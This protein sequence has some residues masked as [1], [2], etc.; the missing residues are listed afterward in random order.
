[1]EITI[2]LA[3]FGD[4][5]KLLIAI[6]ALNEE[7]SI[8]AVVESALAARAT[9]VAETP[10]S[11]VDIT[12]VSDGST[13]RTA[14]IAGQYL[15]QINLII[16]DHNRG[17]GAAIKDAWERSDADLLGFMDAD[18]TCNPSFFG[19]LCR[20]LLSKNADIVLGSRLSAASRIPLIRR[21][22]NLFFSLLLTLF[23]SRLVRDAASGMRVVRRSCLPRLMPLPDGLHFTPAMS[24]RAVLSDD[25]K[26]FEVDMPY[27]ERE[28]R[29]KLGVFK[30]GLRFLRV[31]L[32]TT[33]LYRPSRPLV[34]FG[35]ICFAVASALMLNPVL[36]YFQHRSVL[37]WMIYRFVVSDLL[38]SSA[39]LFVC[40][41]Y[42]SRKVVRITLIDKVRAKSGRE[43]PDVFFSHPLFWVV[44]LLLLSIGG[45]LIAPSVWQLF[46]TGATYEHW[47]R[48][49]AMSFLVSVAVTLVVTRLLSYVL[50]LI[51]S[52]LAYERLHRLHESEPQVYAAGAVT[53]QAPGQSELS[54][55]TLGVSRTHNV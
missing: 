30:D 4:S 1:M 27:R 29:S 34:I 49:I 53:I 47:S 16:Y 10:V 36:Y 25:L 26:I 5:V 52:R 3:L 11:Q 48:F 32:E 55:S 2:Y 39:C 20:E 42:L 35:L 21:I 54:S 31:I 18:G 33:F 22:G 50:D 15:N 46:K 14:E 13:D 12:V 19:T 8:A 24:A 37:E 28:G 9:I 40:A 51:T 38:G 17:Y 45:L 6:P 7:G 41:G 23:S 43:W 44:P